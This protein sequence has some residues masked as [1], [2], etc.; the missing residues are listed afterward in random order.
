[1]S[2]DIRSWLERFGFGKYAD[3]F[4]EN[5]IDFRALLRLTENDLK[6]LGLPLGARR[7][8]QAAIEQISDEDTNLT[9]GA[10]S[11][12]SRTTG[13]AERRQLTVVFCDLVGSTQLSQ[14]HDPEVLREINRAYQDACKAAIER[15]DGYVAR[16]MGDGVLAYFGYPKA[17]EDDAERSVH[18]GLG[19]VEAMA[20]LNETV[21][22]RHGVELNV[23][24]GIATGPVVVGD[25]I[26]E[27]AS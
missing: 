4:A 1:M 26:G 16:Y 27:A 24:V 11:I 10:Q 6:E 15:Y 5:E 3:V 23:R 9:A 8:L 21:G 13:E 2:H 18:A 25:L 14:K 19:V 7:N 20:G 17:H 12:E 22:D